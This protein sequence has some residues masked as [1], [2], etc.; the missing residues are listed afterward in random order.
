M[1]E[2]IE[3]IDFLIITPLEEERDAVLSLLDQPR[4]LPP[5]DEDN[6]VYFESRMV[7][8]LKARN[9][10][11]YRIVVVPLVGMG[12][13]QASATTSDAIRR[14]CPRYVL[15]VGIAGGVRRNGVALGDVLVASQIADYTL[16][17]HPSGKPVEIRWQ[18]Q[19]VDAGLLERAQNHLDTNWISAIG[20]RR[21]VKGEPKRHIGPIASGDHVVASEELLGAYSAPW[22]KLIGVEMEAAGIARV[23]FQSKPKAGFFM[24]RGVSDLADPDKDS[25]QV[26]KYRTYACKVAAAYAISFLRTGPVTFAEHAVTTASASQTLPQ[27]YS[28]NTISEEIMTNP[29]PKKKTILAVFANPRTLPALR[30]AEEDRAIRE[31][32]QLS[33]HRDAF[34]IETAP[35]ATMNDIAR[36]L[37]RTKPDILHISGHGSGCGL[38]LETPTGGVHVVPQA[39]LAELV[40]QYAPPSG[41]L[42]CVILNAC[43]SLT[44]GKLASVGV[45]S[46]IATEGEIDDPAAI[47]FS[48]GFYDAVG[49]GYKYTRSYK[50]GCLRA[51]LNAPGTLWKVCLLERGE[52]IEKAEDKGGDSPQRSSPSLAPSAQSTLL[53][54]SVDL[55]GSMKASMA[56]RDRRQLSRFDA[57]Q[58]SLER[59]ISEAEARLGNEGEGSDRLRTFVYGFGLR[60]VP[61]ADLL[62]ALQAVSDSSFRAL[63]ESVKNRVVSRERDRYSGLDELASLAA[64]YLG[65]GTVRAI[66]GQAE[67]RVREAIFQELNPVLEEK[68]RDI[69][70]VTVRLADLAKR[71]RGRSGSFKDAEPVLFGGTPMCA[72]LAAIGERFK[73]E[74]PKCAPG[75]VP[76]LFVLSDGEADDGDAGRFR[77]TFSSLGVTVVSCFVS[78]HDVAV[79]RIIF[80]NP[81]PNWNRGARQMFE[82]ASVM[83][84]DSGFAK[85]LLQKGWTIEPNAKLFVQANHSEIME[86]F[87]SIVLG[88]LSPT[89]V[90]GLLPYGV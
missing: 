81:E 54:I 37:L 7:V 5:S 52:V 46:T 71:W 67:D 90:G 65:A 17:K 87:M 76:V 86:E 44:Q 64:H 23:A 6:R 26:K 21:P 41:T 68:L 12:T 62:A 80:G 45:E 75:T 51:K 82:L 20:C 3:K 58:N 57:F 85:M 77:E 39:A 22:P 28:N 43:Y 83:P 69:G 63:A 48:R 70:D 61:H 55:S 59:L 40:S 15:V 11:E 84:L 74:I 56:N 25:M 31:S 36:A 72:A 24:V 30:L 10:G 50:E 1:P 53:G 78:D 4:Q 33:E 79:P 35:A 18:A 14:W 34:R 19:P 89:A 47:E 60:I 38:L 13:G 16:Q 88:P 2:S 27:S 42:G 29:S 32:I 66:A 9:K 49:A 8:E 73:R